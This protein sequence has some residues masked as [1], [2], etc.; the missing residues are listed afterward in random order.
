[1][2]MQCVYCVVLAEFFN[3]IQ[4]KFNLQMMT[5]KWIEYLISSLQDI[6]PKDIRS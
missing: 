3:I 5:Y 6:I 4:A 1:M 2:K